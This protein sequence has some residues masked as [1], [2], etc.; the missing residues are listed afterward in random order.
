MMK[1]ARPGSSRAGVDV[2]QATGLRSQVGDSFLAPSVRR[3]EAEKSTKG[4]SAFTKRTTTLIRLYGA[5][6][7][8]YRPVV[9]TVSKRGI[10]L[11]ALPFLLVFRLSSDA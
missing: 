6:F 7:E 11:R 3:E 9:R 2:L 10:V 1:S 8:A 5:L 4:S